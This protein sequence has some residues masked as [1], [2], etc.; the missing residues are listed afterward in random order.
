MSK[1]YGLIFDVD[2]LIANTEPVN[3][4]VT[5]RVFEDIF[6]VRGVRAEDFAAG[7]GRGAEAFVRAGADVRRIDLTDEQVAQAVQLRERYLI[8]TIGEEGVPAFAGVRELI[9]AALARPD[10]RLAIAT[11]ASLEL[12]RAILEST[13]V[14]YARMA[15]VSGSDVTRKKPDPQVFL[16]AAERIGIEP[17]RCVVFEDA[18]SGVRAAKAAGARCVAVTNSAPAEQ[19]A[20]ADIVCDSLEQITLDTITNL[21]DEK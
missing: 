21:I 5:I 19:L 14:P 11:S 4:K 1:L 10:C 3:A 17:A 20:P 6:G 13:G 16:L 15:Y 7:I 2:G 12:S 9:G 18:P 8:D